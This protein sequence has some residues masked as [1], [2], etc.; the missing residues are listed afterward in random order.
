M[1]NDCPIVNES[2][3]G[4]YMLY[5]STQKL[6]ESCQQ[7]YVTHAKP[8]S[9]YSASSFDLFNNITQ[10]LLPRRFQDT[11]IPSID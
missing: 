10:S 5:K 2:R 6:E 11:Q 7:M 4:Q 9:K 1:Q 8:F 3:E